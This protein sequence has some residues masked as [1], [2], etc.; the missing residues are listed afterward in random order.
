MHCPQIRGIVAT[1]EASKDTDML[2][3]VRGPAARPPPLCCQCA[4]YSACPP[5]QLRQRHVLWSI[6]IG[7]MLSFF[8]Q[9]RAPPFPSLPPPAD[10]CLPL[11]AAAS[12]A[13]AT[14]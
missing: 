12:G 9:V 14:P 11:L 10:G 2:T 1:V 4:P 6:S 3:E 7:I 13:A 8:Q 5:L